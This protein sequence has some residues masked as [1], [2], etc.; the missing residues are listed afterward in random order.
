MDRHNQYVDK[1]NRKRLRPCIECSKASV[2]CYGALHRGLCSRCENLGKECSYQPLDV[3]VLLAFI[4]IHHAKFNGIACYHCRS[5]NKSCSYHLP[6]CMPCLLAG[7]KCSYQT[8]PP[9]YIIKDVL[10]ALCHRHKT[11]TLA[12]KSNIRGVR[13]NTSDA[14]LVNKALI[15]EITD[16]SESEED[17]GPVLD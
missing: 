1:I 16:D 6:W 4:A 11:L 14:E 2:R 13:I 7:R 9:G 8:L 5:Q 12:S 15:E 10:K 3:N 17:G